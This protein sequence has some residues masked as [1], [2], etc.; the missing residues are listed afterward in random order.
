MNISKLIWPVLLLLL[1][2][3]I[4]FYLTGAII[5]GTDSSSFLSTV[6]LSGTGQGIKDLQAQSSELN[7]ALANANTLTTVAG[8]LQTK[9]AQIPADELARL[10]EFLPDTNDNVDLVVKLNNI[11]TGRGL[12]L[13]NV[14]IGDG[15]N[16]PSAA[17]SGVSATFSTTTSLTNNIGE[18]DISFTVSGPYALFLGFLS[19]M[20]DSLRLLDIK[21]LSFSADDKDNSQY[22]VVLK[23]YWVK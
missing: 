7:Q 11:A 23:T 12:L 22:N 9:M 18:T 14:K 20:S 15:Q 2:G 3:F 21:S 10:N 16:T 19:D 4:A 17:A 13:K 1:A 8:N 6:F 5:N